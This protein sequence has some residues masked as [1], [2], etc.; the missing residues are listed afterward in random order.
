MNTRFMKFIPIM[1]LFFGFMQNY[2]LGSD[3][4]II[5]NKDVPENSL[6]A[7]EIKDIFTWNKKNWEDGSRITFVLMRNKA[8]LNAFSREYLGKTMMQYEMFIKNEVFIDG[9]KIPKSFKTDEQVIQY[10]SITKGSIG[11]ISKEPDTWLVKPMAI[12]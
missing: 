9:N 10:V 8:V 4:V 6:T 12:K 5:C 3:C 7:K 11:F 1:I 2:A